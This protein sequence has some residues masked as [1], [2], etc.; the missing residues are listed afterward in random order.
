MLPIAR[1]LSSVRTTGLSTADDII[2]ADINRGRGSQNANLVSFTYTLQ[3]S[4]LMSLGMPDFPIEN[5]KHIVEI[6][7]SK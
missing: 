1:L 2:T 6:M 5:L 3:S 7:V 4:E